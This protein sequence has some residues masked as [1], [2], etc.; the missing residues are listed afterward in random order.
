MNIEE[1]IKEKNC[2]YTAEVG[3]LYGRTSDIILSTCNNIKVHYMIDPWADYTKIG[4]SD[5]KDKG[6]LSNDQKKWEDIYSKCC[7]LMEKYCNRCKIIRAKSVEG[8]ELVNTLLDVVIVDADHTRRPFLLD[9]VTWLPKCKDTGMWVN[10]DY[11]GGWYDVVDVCNEVFGKENLKKI[12]RT[13][14]YV[15]LTKESKEL[16]LNRANELLQSLE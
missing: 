11:G 1:L 2:E 8:S 9:I 16:F 13:Y 5:S 3:C 7:N 6:L 14:V 12:A 10:H 15:E 4:Q